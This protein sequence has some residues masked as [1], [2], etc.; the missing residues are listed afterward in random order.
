MAHA[1][2]VIHPRTDNIGILSTNSKDAIR[3][4]KAGEE[5]AIESLPA[6]K[7]KLEALKTAHAD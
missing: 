7:Q 1:D 4:I 2:L 5:A 3:G 6:I